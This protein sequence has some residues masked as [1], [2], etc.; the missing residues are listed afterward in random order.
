MVI[1]F[2][3]IMLRQ[4]RSPLLI[5]MF[6]F[7]FAIMKELGHAVLHLPKIENSD[8]E[9]VAKTGVHSMESAATNF[10][11][12]RLLPSDILNG[13]SDLKSLNQENIIELSIKHRINQDIIFGILSRKEKISVVESKS[14]MEI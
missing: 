6:W 1:H 4:L 9:L 3:Q 5:R 14:G 13:V 2:G 11:I 10:A 7:F 8:E 12:N